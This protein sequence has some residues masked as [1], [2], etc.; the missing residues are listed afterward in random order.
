MTY[1]QEQ[2]SVPKYYIKIISININTLNYQLEMTKKM[3]CDYRA[4]DNM[5][6]C[7]SVI[8]QHELSPSSHCI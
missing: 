5:W 8:N 3:H 7:A 2:R 6:I 1:N 4:V